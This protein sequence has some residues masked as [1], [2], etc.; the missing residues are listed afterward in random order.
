MVELNYSLKKITGVKN[1]FC[2]LNFS[3]CIL[4]EF[5]LFTA[6]WHFMVNTA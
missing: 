2:I 6:T 3:F 4:C 1:F 5:Q